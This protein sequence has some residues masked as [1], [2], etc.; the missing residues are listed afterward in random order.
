MAK[1]VWIVCYVDITQLDRLQRDLAKKYRRYSKIQAYVPTVQILDKTFKKKDT[2]KEVPLFM[3]YGFFNVP[4]HFLYNDELLRTFKDDITAVYQYLK[5]PAKVKIRKKKKRKINVISTVSDAEIDKIKETCDKF[6]IY[7]DEDAQNLKVGDVVNLK[8]Y[9]FENMTGT[10]ISLNLPKKEAKV[11]IHTDMSLSPKITIAFEHLFYSI[12]NAE[13]IVSSGKEV[14][15]DDL[16]D[17][18]FS[19][20]KY[21][22]NHESME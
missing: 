22:Y 14:S 19:I 13:S 12:H 5:D 18:G 6:K 2:Y 9:P 7:S 20:D 11:E 4:E 1:Y 8:K 16:T 17:N 10:I 21:Y 3:N 15:L